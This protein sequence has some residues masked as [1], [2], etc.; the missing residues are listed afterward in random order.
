MNQDRIR[1]FAATLQLELPTITG[2]DPFGLTVR[3]PLEGIWD[4]V[5]RLPQ[6]SRDQLKRI[7]IQ[8]VTPGYFATLGIPLLAGRDFGPEDDR[9]PVI[10]VNEAATRH[11]P[12]VP[13]AL[14]QTVIVAGTARQ[15]I[16]VVRNTYTAE[17]DHI[18]PMLYQPLAGNDSPKVIFRSSNAAI[19][20]AIEELAGR[21]Q[22]GIR[23]ETIPLSQY[24]DRRLAPSRASA[25]IAG[26][27]GAFALALAT[28]GMFGVFAYAVQQRTKEIGIR[29]ALG[30]R[31]AH[32]VGLVVAGTARALAVGLIAGFA[33]AAAAAQLIREYLHGLSPFDP[34][35]YAF[36][37]TILAIAG[38]GA[39][40]LPSRRA[41]RIDPVTALR[42]D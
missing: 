2:S 22:P 20:R 8:E 30:A 36:S 3:A 13:R 23:A 21:A 5:Y 32:V 12:S 25:Q 37:A 42:H 1:Q 39:S 35:S 4:T 26:I 33:A 24:V 41:S 19:S 14:G 10:V 18:M 31:S 15:I 34:S 17:F 11:W 16:G 6:E 40:Y 27:L 38:L 28:V 9:R 29:M 7:E